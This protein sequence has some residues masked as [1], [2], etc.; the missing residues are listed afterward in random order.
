MTYRSK[1]SVG[2]FS[3]IEENNKRENRETEDIPYFLIHKEIKPIPKSRD[4]NYS[5]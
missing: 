4:P 5:Y 3:S 1:F 2:F